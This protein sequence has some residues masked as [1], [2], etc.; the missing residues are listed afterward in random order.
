MEIH[1][2]DRGYD[3]R[4]MDVSLIAILTVAVVALAFSALDVLRKLLAEDVGPLPLLV[5][6]TLGAMPLFLLWAG[7]EGVWQVAPAY[8]V[9]AV[10]SILLNIVANLAFLQARAKIR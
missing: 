4:A 5:L 8:V 2:P 9:P 7:S 3:P 6:L 1:G 10:L